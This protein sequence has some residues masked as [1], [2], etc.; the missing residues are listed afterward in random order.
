[1]V[2]DQKVRIHS[3]NLQ[4]QV[5]GKAIFNS[6]QQTLAI[7]DHENQSLFVLNVQSIEKIGGTLS[8]AVGA[9]HQQMENLPANQ[10]DKMLDMIRG[11]GLSVPEQETPRLQLKTGSERS[12]KGI[13]C[14]EH[15]LLVEQ[16]EVALVCLSRAN[17][18]GISDADYNS[19][20]SAQSF[21]L[22]AASQAN[23]LAE[24]HGQKIPNF[25]GLSLNSLLVHSA[26]QEIY[27]GSAKQAV[28]AS[29]SID[30]VSTVKLDNIITP[31]GYQRRSLPF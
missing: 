31:Q 10:R 9:V 16:I 7:V 8:A 15:Q 27:D 18:L 3:R 19:L 20:L 14:V 11:F 13:K 30:Q 17:S 6:Q 29:F 21:M 1:L 12:Y 24:Q 26:Q 2:K 22:N 28:K 4:G 5:A 23:R 25:K